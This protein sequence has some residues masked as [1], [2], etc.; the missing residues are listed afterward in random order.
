MSDESTSERDVTGRPF[1]DDLVELHIR[2]GE[3]SGWE[4]KEVAFRGNKFA[5]HQ[6]DSWARSIV[7]FANADGGVLLLGVTD[8]GV[9]SGMS[10][11]QMD[12][13]ERAVREVCSDAVKPPVRVQIH[14]RELRGRAFLLVAVPRGDAQHDG[15]GG[16][17]QRVGAETMLMSPDERLRLAQRRGQGRFVGFDHQP[18]RGTGFSTLDEDLWRP[19]LSDDGLADPRVG[20]AK[21]GLLIQDESGEERVSVAGAL[22]CTRRPAEWLPSAMISAV[23]YRGADRASGQLDAQNI[24]GPLDR[25]VRDALLFVQRNMRISAHKTPAREDLPEYSLAAVFEA[26]VNAVVHRDYALHVSRIRLS[27][28]SDRLE[29]C[30]PGSLPNSLS[31]DSM[32]ER[33]AT[34]NELLTSVFGRL[35]ASGIDAAGRSYFMERRGDGVAIIRRETQALTGKL[36]TWRLLDGDELCL[37]IPAAPPP[38]EPATPIVTVRSAGKPL[39][40]ATVLALFPNKTWKRS[41]TDSQGE[42]Q[43]ELHSAELPMTVFAASE[44]CAAHV[45]QGWVPAER[46]L[47]VDLA[48]APAGGSAVFAESTGYLPGLAGRLNPIRDTHDRTY[49]YADNI[50][51]NDGQQQPVHFAPGTEQLRLEDSNGQVLLVTVTAVEG[52]SSLLDYRRP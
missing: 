38:A 50:A 27:M 30:S 6:R 21:L 19:L 18:V 41:V 7:A 24:D 8:A 31:I 44:G 45:E 28:F 10:R 51:I 29:L 42:A 22:M 52:R 43:L 25:Q 46:A 9:I 36:P 15:P 32:G 11:E 2:L 47:A 37:T 1:P 13:V 14:R 3:D 5:S 48:A 40:G 12:E 20:L 35:D 4:F 26:V 34:R 49:L 17:F 39:E 23:R 33:Q 16:A